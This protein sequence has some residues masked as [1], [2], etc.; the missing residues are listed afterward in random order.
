MYLAM[1]RFRV[2]EGREQAFIDVWKNR[3]S[4]LEE[5]PGFKSFNLLRSET[6]NG[7][8]LFA[9]H[10]VWENQQSFKDWTR[11]ESFRKAH[12]RVGNTP[13]GIYAGSP[14]LELYESVL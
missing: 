4:Y 2:N 10:S 13:E 8:T 11:S 3:E 6:K 1:N 9:S 5:V 12:S 7:I 14:E